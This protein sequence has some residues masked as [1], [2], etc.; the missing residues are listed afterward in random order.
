[1]ALGGGSW[2]A[3]N[4]V[5]PGAYINFVSASSASAELSDR[6]ICT[7]PLEIDWGV[8]NEVFTVTNADFQKN[9]RKIFGYSYDAPEL[10]EIRDLFLGTQTL[11]AYRLTSGGTKASN[12]YATALYGGTRGNDIK[13]AIQTNVDDTQKYDVITYLDDQ[14][15]DTQTVSAASDLNAN[16]FVEFKASESLAVTASTPL[17]GGTNGMV[18]GTA[19]QNYLDKIESYTYN[20]MGVAVTDDT[21]KK[22][23]VSFNKRMRDE[24]GK[25]CQLVVYNYSA[26]DYVGVIS[27]KNKVLDDGANDASLIYWV[28]GMEASCAVNKTLLNKSYTGE[29]TVDTDY[30][31][32]QLEAA[33][34]SGEFMFHRVNEDVNVLEDIN[35]FTTYSDDMGEDFSSNQTIRVLDQLGNDI[36][37]VFNTK[38]LGNVQNTQN[39]RESFWSDIV[40]ICNQLQNIN[41]I[42]NFD[43][44]TITVE[45]GETK[46]SVVVNGGPINV[47][48]AM[49]Q[50]YMTV[51]VA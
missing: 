19:H 15:V 28:A 30:T 26:A 40:D 45:R 33:I 35:T 47:V 50:L 39:G 41:A 18:N 48:N 22:L 42:E 32:A 43:S 4:K 46:K 12:D 8:E 51:Q 3:Q 17:T 10:K 11:H 23:Y 20:V 5:L 24:V 36:A 37:F 6:G 25:K 34:K 2:V 13:I 49:S 27:V 29:F 21:T 38:Y 16:D 9:S 14:K 31:Q 44:S 1:M 7:M